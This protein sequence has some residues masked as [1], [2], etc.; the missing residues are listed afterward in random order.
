ML[1]SLAQKQIDNKKIDNKKIDNTQTASSL[2]DALDS[3][4][5]HWLVVDS[6]RAEDAMELAYT[7]EKQPELQKLFVNSP[8]EYLLEQS[9][10]IF[11]ISANSELL[12]V[13]QQSAI[14]RTSGVLFS[15]PK[16]TDVLAEGGLIEHL[17]ALMRVKITGKVILFRFYSSKIWQSVACDL[18]VNDIHTLLGPAVSLS[19]IDK[20]QNMQSLSSASQSLS[21]SETRARSANLIDSS[22]IW[23]APPT[24]YVLQSSVWTKWI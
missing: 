4:L 17:Q 18:S 12:N 6:T 10:V 5:D 13:W 16:G 21:D 14:W 2:M 8:F 9:P 20:Q 22:E 15:T 19:W 11:R 7:H 23:V 1:A 3:R 24:P